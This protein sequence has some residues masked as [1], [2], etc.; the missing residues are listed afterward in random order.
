LKE[1]ILP[2]NNQQMNDFCREKGFIGWFETSAKNNTNIE[3]ANRFL[4]S[5]VFLFFKS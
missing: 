4:V 5:K 1:E 2:K 3:E